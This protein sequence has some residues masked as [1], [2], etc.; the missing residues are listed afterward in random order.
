VR[1]KVLQDF[2]NTLCQQF[3]DLGSGHDVKTFVSSGSGLY[4]MNI[5]SGEC[6]HDGAPIPELKACREYRSWLGEQMTKRNVP[7][8]LLRAELAV[9]V[10][11]R[12]ASIRESAGTRFGSADL[13]FHCRAELATDEKVYIGE[14]SGP[15]AWGYMP[16]L[17]F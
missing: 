10:T 3:L 7:P 13:E 5:L 8:G 11:V 17:D 16:D 14:I 12:K 6:S 2:A 4:S 1:R 9:R 15:H